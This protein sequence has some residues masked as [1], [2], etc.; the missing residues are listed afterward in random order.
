MPTRIRSIAVMPPPSVNQAET[1]S[2]KQACSLAH[3][4]GNVSTFMV[5]EPEIFVNCKLGY[6]DILLPSVWTLTRQ[7]FTTHTS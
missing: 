6:V 4:M 1:A 7:V 2:S 3:N 5:A